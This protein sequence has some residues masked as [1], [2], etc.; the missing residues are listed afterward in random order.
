MIPAAELTLTTSMLVTRNI[1]GKT[2]GQNVSEE[3]MGKL[4]RTMVFVLAIVALYLAIFQ[5]RALVNLLLTGYSGVTQFFPMIV[6][7]LIWKKATKIAA[8]ASV[9]VGEG[10][11][12]YWLIWAKMDPLPMEFLGGHVNAGFAALVI[13][14]IVFVVVSLMTYKPGRGVLNN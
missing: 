7:G 8:F 2:A 12:F 5:S 10:L 14:I 13:N 3:K 4:A 9:I 11:V 6:L 1:Y